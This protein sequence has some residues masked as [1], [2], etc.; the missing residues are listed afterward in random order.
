MNPKCKI[1]DD[2]KSGRARGSPATIL[3]HA[4]PASLILDRD[5][6]NVDAMKIPFVNEGESRSL[7]NR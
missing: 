5:W 6:S 7:V 4:G 3:H 1:T 2:S